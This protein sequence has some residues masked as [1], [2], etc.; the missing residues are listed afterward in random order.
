MNND[1]LEN[2]NEEINECTARGA[3]SIAPNI[4]ALQELVMY[5]LKQS[6]FY[7]L[8]LEKLGA[9]NPSIKAEI[10]NDLS[11]LIFV[12]E[13]NEEQIFTIAMKGYFLLQNTKQTYKK[14]NN[15]INSLELKNKINFNNN[16][17]LAKAISYGENLLRHKY[18]NIQ[19]EKNSKLFVRRSN[20]CGFIQLLP[21]FG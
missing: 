16:T 20:A 3:C 9:N 4:A 6:A 15:S 10:I 11:A 1:N 13:F 17:N 19:K 18:N 21:V 7:L 12:N 2:F 14:L 5:F 8:K